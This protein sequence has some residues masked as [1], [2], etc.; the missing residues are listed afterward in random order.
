MVLGSL[1]L[2]KL[3]EAVLQEIL[4]RCGP[5]STRWLP[6]HADKAA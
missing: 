5:A 2:L 3:P 4:S 6:V 1:T